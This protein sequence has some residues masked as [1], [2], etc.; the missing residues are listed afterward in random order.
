MKIKAV[1]C[2]DIIRLGE[3]RIKERNPYLVSKIIIREEQEA[4]IR[5]FLIRAKNQQIR[6]MTYRVEMTTNH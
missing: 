1:A 6:M 4:L 2:Q 5:T 3:M